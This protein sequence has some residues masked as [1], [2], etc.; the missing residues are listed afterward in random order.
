MA[1]IDMIDPELAAALAVLASEAMANGPVTLPERG[2]ALGLRAL[3][4]TGMAGV[5]SPPSAGVF[6]SSFLAS[7]PDGAEIEVRWYAVDSD[8]TKCS[9]AVV[10]LHGGGMVAGKIDYYDGLVRHYVQESAVPMLLVDYRLAPERTG[11]GLAEDGFA[12]L[13]WLLD[14]A[15]ELGV[16]AA[17]IAV[18]GDSGGG[19]V[20]AGTAILARDR[21]VSLAK[22]ILVYPMLDDRTVEPDPGLEGVVAWDYSSNWTCWNAVLGNDFGSDTISPVAAPGRL[23][24]FAGL[25]P[26]YIEVG[27]LDIFRDECIDYAHGLYKAGISCELHVLPGV[28]HGHDRMSVDIE[29]T[30][31][32][33]ADRSRVIAAL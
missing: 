19:G 21:G 29:V 3:I 6:M 13:Q 8:T 23:E 33:L 16:D 14:H 32:T 26:A 9:P 11:T 5:P 10:Y 31:R 1:T 25:P 7:T 27:E 17:R 15:D 12:G 28:V 4:D 30:R 18:M 2:D 22:Q 24:D 20:A